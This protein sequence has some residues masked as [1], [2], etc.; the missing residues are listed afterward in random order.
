MLREKKNAMKRL[1]QA[2]TYIN[3]HYCEK[4]TL[5][6]VAASVYMS[7]NYFSS[8]FRKFTNISFSDYVT[9]LR[10]N[11]ARELLREDGANVTEI[12]LHV[13][14][15]IFPIFTDYI[16][17]IWEKLPDMRRVKIIKIQERI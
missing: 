3:A 1:E 4:I 13:G 7:S 2:F 9:R 12:A 8:Y 17:S 14:S 16:R 6:E 15:I 5:E 11:R 10:V